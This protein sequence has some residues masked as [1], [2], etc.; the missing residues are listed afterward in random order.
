VFKISR[1][2]SDSS[3]F[4]GSLSFTPWDRGDRS[5][6]SVA[7]FDGELISGIIRL[8]LVG[9]INTWILYRRTIALSSSKSGL[10]SSQSE[11]A[12]TLLDL[13]E[14]KRGYADTVADVFGMEQQEGIPI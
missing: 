9:I 4:E 14:L 3:S 2:F 10:E 7:K 12:T 5:V 13:V 8:I 6:I 1:V 11:G